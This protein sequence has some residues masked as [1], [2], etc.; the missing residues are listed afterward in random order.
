MIIILIRIKLF[1]YNKHCA[2]LS[3]VKKKQSKSGALVPSEKG[4]FLLKAYYRFSMP[5]FQ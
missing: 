4:I 3:K 5:F 2:P 1:L